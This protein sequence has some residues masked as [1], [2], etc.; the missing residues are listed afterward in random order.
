[1]KDIAIIG[2]GFSAASFSYFI[3]KDL[4]FYEKSRGVGGRCSTRRVENVGLFD[5]GLQ[6]I[7]KPSSE[8][9]KMLNDYSFWQGNFKIFE[10]NQ[11]K[12][13]ADKERVIN[14]NGNNSLVKNLFKNNENIFVNKELKSIEKKSDHLQLTFKDD[15]IEQYKT[16]IITAPFQ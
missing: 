4:D 2:T 8:F 9:K 1:M 7:N 13:D 12:D 10:N 3:K 11:L 14:E 5:H 15:T 6:Y 16:V